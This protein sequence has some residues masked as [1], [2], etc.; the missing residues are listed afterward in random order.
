MPLTS[1]PRRPRVSCP[2]DYALCPCSGRRDRLCGWLCVVLHERAYRRA[3]VR[4]GI[5][6]REPGHPRATAPDPVHACVQL[7]HARV[8]RLPRRPRSSLARP[9]PRLALWLWRH[10]LARHRS[11]QRCVSRPGAQ[12]GRGWYQGEAEGRPGAV[13]TR[14]QEGGRGVDADDAELYGVRRHQPAHGVLLLRLLGGRGAVGVGRARGACMRFRG[15]QVGSDEACC[16]GGSRYTTRSGRSTS[17]SWRRAWARTGTV[18]PGASSCSHFA[19][20]TCTHVCRRAGRFDHQW[21]FAREFHVSP[22]NDRLGHYRVSVN[23]PPAPSSSSSALASSPP[24]PKVRI[25]LHAASS[26]TDANADAAGSVGPL[27]LTATLF[28]RRA[29]PLTSA[30]LLRALAQYPFALFL[31][32]ARILYHAWILHYGK[33]LDVFPRPDPKPAMRAWGL[34][35]PRAV[36]SPTAAEGDEDKEARRRAHGGIGWQDEGPL[37]AYARRVVERFLARRAE[38]LGVEL[39]LESGDPSVPRR[40]FVPSSTSPEDR[41]VIRYAALRFF[42]T[43]LLAPCAAHML[44]VGTAEDLFRVSS[45]ELF[46]RVFAGAAWPRMSWVQSL[47]LSLLPKRFARRPSQV[48]PRHSLD[49]GWGFLNALVVCLVHTGDLLEKTVFTGLKA[50]FVPGLEPWGR[51]ERAAMLLR[52]DQ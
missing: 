10:L 9:R 15:S 17:M 34:P 21:T 18:R 6:R 43:L 40:V 1:P 52:D 2:L 22:F 13:R 27:K 41:L 23:A 33:R 42:P 44:L 50:R 11:A 14:Q 51:W 26:S 16:R 20:R 37:E 7:P 28:A 46:V 35:L 24:R 38:E 48:P 31:S 3:E 12:E 8:L 39:V 49:E 30:H 25:H 29:V 47:R 19:S 5:H 4:T 32:F 36:L 45:E